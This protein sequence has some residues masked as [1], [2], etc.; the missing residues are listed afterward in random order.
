MSDLL[1]VLA[2]R[3]PGL[4]GRAAA[5]LRQTYRVCSPLHNITGLLSY[6][7]N[8]PCSLAESLAKDRY[9]SGHLCLLYTRILFV[10]TV[11]IW[12]SIELGGRY[13]SVGSH[14]LNPEAVSNAEFRKSD[15]FYQTIGGIARAAEESCP[16][17]WSGICIV[18]QKLEMRCLCIKW[19]IAERSINGFVN[20]VSPSG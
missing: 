15:V 2:L 4:P 17:G 19:N 9:E 10:E 6:E 1:T 14:I 16:N 11:R 20:R 12:K 3:L 5:A 8:R 18:C 13:Q 7:A